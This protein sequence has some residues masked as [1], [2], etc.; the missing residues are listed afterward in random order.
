MD[1]QTYKNMQFLSLRI[2]KSPWH[3]LLKLMEGSKDLCV[4]FASHFLVSKLSPLPSCDMEH[5]N[6]VSVQIF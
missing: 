1:C 5:L 3:P 6:R 4:K 2:F